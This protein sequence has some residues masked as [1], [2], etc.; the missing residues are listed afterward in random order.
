[1]VELGFDKAVFPHPKPVGML[2]R[3]LEFATSPQQEDIV[4]DF[5]AGSNVTA[6]EV[7]ELNAIDGGGRRFICVQL[8][9]ELPDGSVARRDGSSSQGR[10][11]TMVPHLFP[12]LH[13]GRQPLLLGLLRQLHFK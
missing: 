8:P 12:V 6:Q 3:I 9:Q 10:R 13:V 2:R 1:M 5:F 11:D 7:L 4:L